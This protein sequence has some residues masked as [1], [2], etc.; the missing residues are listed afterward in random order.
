MQV[1]SQQFETRVAV[2]NL[3]Q[4][5]G[6][7]TA[8]EAAHQYKSIIFTYLKLVQSLLGLVSL[9]HAK[10]SAVTLQTGARVAELI[11]P[12]VILHTQT[13]IRAC[14]IF[15]WIVMRTWN[16]VHKSADDHVSALKCQR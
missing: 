11:G 5:V 9:T 1:L 12:T 10:R 4:R 13:A 3:A 14:C 8:R 7:H 6:Q 16:C 2:N 15:T